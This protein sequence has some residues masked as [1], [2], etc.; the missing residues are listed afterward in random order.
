MNGRTF[1]GA[2]LLAAPGQR[3]VE[4]QSVSKHYNQ[5]NGLVRAVDEV[6]L[7]VCSGDFLHITGRSGSGKSTLLSLIGGLA[8]PTAG[9]VK[10]LDR[11]LQA[12]DDK[13]ISHLR[14][15]AM[16]F[17]F[18]FSSLI[19]T[20]SVI[21]NVRLPGLFAGGSHNDERAA[22]L[23]TWVGLFNKK[24]SFPS[25]LSSG[26]ATR[27]ALARSLVNKPVIL[28]ADE[29]TGNLDVETEIDILR[30][31]Q[32]INREEGLTIVMVTHN[33]DL[34][35]FGNRHAIME[36]GRLKEVE[37]SPSVKAARA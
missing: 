18:Q 33:P 36:M 17:V 31:L 13:Q 1:T 8:A 11:D 26:Q 7:E 2:S 25:Q 20:L 37:I 4:L 22:E 19:P 27:V 21:D 12:L 24:N 16:G 15:T 34:I 6:S 14:A 30:L 35:H 29:P 23:L 9:T 5:G 28:L 3:V 10:V 32:Q